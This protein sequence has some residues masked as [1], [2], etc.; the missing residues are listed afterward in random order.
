MQLYSTAELILWFSQLCKGVWRHCYTVDF[1]I[2][3]NRKLIHREIVTLWIVVPR[4]V[5]GIVRI[6]PLRFLVGCRTRQL[7]Q[8]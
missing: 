5:S 7:N 1:M 2:W 6:D 3:C 4:A 8:V